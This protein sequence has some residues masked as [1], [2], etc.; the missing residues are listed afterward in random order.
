MSSQEEYP[1]S[2]NL[3]HGEGVVS[4]GQLPVHLRMPDERDIGGADGFFVDWG[5][6]HCGDG[7]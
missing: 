7:S 3:E 5:G 4:A 2:K 6:G 1:E